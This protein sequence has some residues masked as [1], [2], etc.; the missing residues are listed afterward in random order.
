MPRNDR[1]A[2]ACKDIYRHRLQEKSLVLPQGG[3]VIPGGGEGGAQKECTGT[4]TYTHAYI[5]LRNFRRVGVH[6]QLSG[7]RTCMNA[8]KC[9]KLFIAFDDFI[10]S[11]LAEMVELLRNAE[12]RINSKIVP[13]LHHVSSQSVMGGG[14]FPT[15]RERR[16]G[17]LSACC[18]ITC[19]LIGALVTCTGTGRWSEEE[20][21]SLVA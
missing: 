21:K 1:P 15:L 10:R 9:K 20:S 18:G 16:Y 12:A 5:I 2:S 3:D 14:S 17:L 13:F 7:I 19:V 8:H 4:H 6:Q 11:F